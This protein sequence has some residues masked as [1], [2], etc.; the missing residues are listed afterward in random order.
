LRFHTFLGGLIVNEEKRGLSFLRTILGRGLK[1]PTSLADAE[2]KKTVAGPESQVVQNAVGYGQL[3]AS[4]SQEGQE[5]HVF[6]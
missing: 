1:N 5:E 3:Q 2:K 4:Q 6:R